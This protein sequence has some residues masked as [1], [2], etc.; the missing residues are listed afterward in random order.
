MRELVT[1]VRDDLDNTLLADKTV[2]FSWDGVDFEIDLT[3]EHLDQFADDMTNWVTV[4]RKVKRSQKR[5]TPAVPVNTDRQQ[6]PP[7]PAKEDSPSAE[8]KRIRAWANANGHE[9][10]PRGAIPQPIVDAYNAANGDRSP[11]GHAS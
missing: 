5:R 8:R 3:N 6:V 10:S 9:V 11:K 2:Q 4:A 1:V 7:I